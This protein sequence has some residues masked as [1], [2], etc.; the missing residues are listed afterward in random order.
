M[1]LLQIIRIF[2]LTNYQNKD[3][4]FIIEIFGWGLS[5]DSTDYD[6]HIKIF[7]CCSKN[8]AA[9]LILKFFVLNLGSSTVEI[10]IPFDST[11]NYRWF[12]SYL[13][14]Y[15]PCKGHCISYGDAREQVNLSQLCT[16]RLVKSLIPPDNSTA[17]NHWFYHGLVSS[18][19]Q[20]GADPSQGPFQGPEA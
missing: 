5:W 15:Y 6:C 11:K 17:C 8:K 19:D 4:F 9:W 7:I 10:S 14:G 18:V 12:T 16:V 13:H 2:L 3:F 1:P 20:F